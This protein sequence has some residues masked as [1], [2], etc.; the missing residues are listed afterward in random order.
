VK[1]K[2]PQIDSVDHGAEQIRTLARELLPQTESLMAKLQCF[3]SVLKKAI[4][5]SPCEKCP[6][7]AC[8]EPCEAL[9]AHADGPYRGK[10][11]GETTI[12]VNLPD[13]T[14]QQD[15]PKHSDSQ[16]E[17]NTGAMPGLPKPQPIYFDFKRRCVLTSESEGLISDHQS[18]R[19]IEL[20]IRSGTFTLF[21]CFLRF[22]EWRSATHQFDP[23]RRLQFIQSRANSVL[24]PLGLSIGPTGKGAAVYMLAGREPEHHQS[25]T[26]EAFA[27]LQAVVEEERNGLVDKRAAV[28]R[29]LE[30]LDL[31]PQSLPAALYVVKLLNEIKDRTFQ[32]PRE[33]L[34]AITRLLRRQENVY[35]GAIAAIGRCHALQDAGLQEHMDKYQSMLCEIRQA[36][37]LAHNI[38]QFRPIWD[39]EEGRVD[40]IVDHVR[41]IQQTHGGDPGPD[42]GRLLKALLGLEQ[43][44]RAREVVLSKVRRRCPEQWTKENRL[45]EEFEG[46]F[47]R[48]ILEK[49]DCSKLRFTGSLAS[50]MTRS[51][52]T[53]IL[54]S[55]FDQVYG[56]SYTQVK[57]V[58]TFQRARHKW[59]T[60]HGR[61]PPDDEV[62]AELGITQER[63][64]RLQQW[65]RQ[66]KARRFNEER[67]SK[68]DDEP[69]DD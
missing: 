8:D 42:S 38:P 14:A 25:N 40:E 18:W 65:E 48:L 41:A 55:A 3:L 27:R 53:M 61:T 62:A 23:K 32:L 52:P 9:E 30:A 21:D 20:A 5:P 57:S 1:D 15:G 24:R 33:T 63:L 13:S 44:R 43:V 66:L 11:P 31:D 64:R 69:D 50:Y 46:C 10:A 45:E 26:E 58:Q 12:G 67:D 39:G 68:S 36:R 22:V 60:S 35:A 54:D 6:N 4:E 2:R 37:R 49:V 28:D 19:L 47:N 56:L 34:A 17:L 51:M 59:A 16:K 7:K 29:A